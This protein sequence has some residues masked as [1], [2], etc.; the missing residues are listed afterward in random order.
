MYTVLKCMVIKASRK[1]ALSVLYSCLVKNLLTKP[2]QDGGGKVIKREAETHRL[3]LN[4]IW[5]SNSHQNDSVFEQ[6]KKTALL[7]GCRPED[8]FPLSSLINLC[9][10]WQRGGRGGGRQ[11]EFGSCSV[12][13]LEHWRDKWR[14]TLYS[15]LRHFPAH[16][17][18]Y[19]SYNLRYSHMCN[20]FSWETFSPS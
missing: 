5:D 14:N 12:S 7:F 16:L 3:R 20:I 8:V 11:G 13:A 15:T 17:T 18:T 4:N 6:K 1:T 10:E 9:G 2:N 19:K